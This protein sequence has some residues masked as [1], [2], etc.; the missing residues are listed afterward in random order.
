MQ[1]LA[2]PTL[3]SYVGQNIS[4]FCTMGYTANNRNHCAHWVSHVTGIT[5]GYVC[6]NLGPTAK[7]RGQGATIRV[8]DLY[9][10]CGRRGPWAERPMPLIYNLIFVTGAS[11]VTNG[12]MGDN[13][14]KHVGIFHH[15]Y[16]WDYSNK[17]DQVVRNDT[18]EDFLNRLRPDYPADVALFYGYGL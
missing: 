1:T 4:A 5:V 8:D 2:I 9:N 10:R 11:N 7:T 6:G 3:D 14:N 13:P 17:Q 15:P 16:V 12:V 18:P